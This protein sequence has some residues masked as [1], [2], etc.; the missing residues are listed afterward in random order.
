[1]SGVCSTLLPFLTNPLTYLGIGGVTLLGA[2]LYSYS[3][4]TFLPSLV[5]FSRLSSGVNFIFN[6]ITKVINHGA[7]KLV[8]AYTTFEGT[9]SS[10]L[11][12]GFSGQLLLMAG[13][14]FLEK[15]TLSIKN[16]IQGISQLNNWISTADN[17]LCQLV[18][19]NEIL[20]A[21]LLSL[22]TGVAAY[23]F[24][25]WMWNLTW[26]D[27]RNQEME[28]QQLILIIVAVSSLSLAVYGFEVL[29][30]GWSNTFSLVDTLANSTGNMSVNN[31]GHG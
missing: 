3:S 28:Q 8:A 11:Q 1:M 26:Y 31:T 18:Q 17:G 15:T 6:V 20:V 27:W 19:N 14:E 5:L 22:W 13:Q 4:L 25:I 23:I 7:L 2:A 16:L 21:A 10:L 12:D 29:S 24:V 30:Q 9:I